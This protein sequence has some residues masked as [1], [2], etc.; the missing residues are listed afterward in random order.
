MRQSLI[1]L[2]VRRL[3]SSSNYLGSEI[4]LIKVIITV[5]DKSFQIGDGHIGWEK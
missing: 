2:L 3:S 1:E 5:G 4:V